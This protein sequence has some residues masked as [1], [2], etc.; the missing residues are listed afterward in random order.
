MI[1]SAIHTFTYENN[2]IQK[3]QCV[4]ADCFEQL[5][6]FSPAYDEE[7]FLHLHRLYRDYILPKYALLLGTIILFHLPED[8]EIPFPHEYESY[9]KIYD[10]LAIVT[11]NFRENVFLSKGE[12]CFK[13]RVTE[14][15]FRCLQK[16]DA[17]EIIRGK[18]DYISI[19]PVSRR[20]G[21]LSASRK[22]ASLKV[23]ASFFLMDPLDC[24]SVFD[25][26]GLP[27]GLKL[28]NGVILS[29]PLF[30]RET[31]LVSKNGK[32]HIERIFLEKISVIIDNTIYRHG[33]NAVFCSRPKHRKTPSGGFDI[34]I[35]E[36][37]V[38]SVKR[39]G[40]SIVP[41]GG[42][43]VHLEQ[44]IEVASQKV[45]YAG[46][47]DCSFSIQVGNSVIVD[48]R[49]TDG[50]ISKFYRLA[51][52]F[53]AP[54]PPSMYPLS[55][56]KDRA[57]RIV[58]GAD[59]DGK[60]MLLWFEGAGKFGYEKGKESCGTS[61]KEA[62]DIAE[63]LGLYNGIHLDGGGSAQI[64][65]DQE[66]QLKLSDRNPADFTEIERA[67]PSALYIR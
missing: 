47:E 11:I 54:Y 39:G 53:H 57:P 59:R 32:V 67:I 51:D 9:G 36:D 50:F 24:A 3:V 26:I 35:M 27:F 48:G 30:D 28:K 22:D 58:L 8:M 60:P 64:L 45:C 49:K 63:K 2:E 38:V 42:F 4:K 20:A 43:I 52:P 16:L 6:F 18:R 65:I 56:R 44:E 37:C 31:L 34:V 40:N 17:L 15:F 46:L 1:D 62:S 41:A 33:E 55:Y 13:D 61:L 12:I 7:S 23:N 14:D 10:P 19:L 21:F 25:Q 66:R 29:P 5:D